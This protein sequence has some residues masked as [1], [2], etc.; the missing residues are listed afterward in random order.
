MAWPSPPPSSESCATAPLRSGV[1]GASSRPSATRSRRSNASWSPTSPRPGAEPNRPPP[2]VAPAASTHRWT[3]VQLRAGASH[4]PARGPKDPVQR[5]SNEKTRQLRRAPPK[6]SPSF[7]D[8]GTPAARRVRTAR[9]LPETAQ[10]PKESPWRR[11]IVGHRRAGPASQSSPSLSGCHSWYSPQARSRHRGRAPR[12][13]TAVATASRLLPHKLSLAVKRSSSADRALVT[14]A[15]ALKH[16]LATHRSHPR[17]CKAA[18]TGLQRTGAQLAAARRG[19]A[20]VAKE[21][22]HASAATVPAG[23]TTAAPALTAS[24]E[25]L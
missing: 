10:P 8:K 22:A 1:A 15:R 4:S 5:S 14:K 9:G 2:T 6:A 20:Q 23:L 11:F 21:T 18:Q 7:P 13:P 3:S 25:K 16:C 24:G 12:A 17:K 19:L